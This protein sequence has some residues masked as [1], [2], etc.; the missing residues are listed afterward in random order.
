MAETAPIHFAAQNGEDRL[1]M[2]LFGGKTDGFC[3]EVGSLDGLEISN[4]WCFEQLGWKCLL[5]EANPEMARACERNRP[6]SQ[7][8]NA[9]AVA[10]GSPSTIAFQ[11]AD[12]VQ[13]MSAIRLDDERQR[14]ILGYTR[15]LR[16][17]EVTVPGRT[18]DAILTEAQCASPDF[19]SIDVEG[20]EW[21][22]LRGFSL[23]RWKPEVVLVERSGVFPEWR[24]VR[25]FARAGYTLERRTGENDW[26]VRDEKA[27]GSPLPIWIRHYLL[28]LP[29]LLPQWLLQKIKAALYFLGLYKLTRRL[30]R[31]R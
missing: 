4:T 19:V 24:M 25:H 20:H 26:Y 30:V 18:L 28:P 29:T 6:R 5:I 3:V 27:G 13:G 8:I 15:Q 22:V 23:E 31:G 11:V 7:V 16:I 17:R 9:A 21:E 14:R 2:S 1:L 12:D 10:P